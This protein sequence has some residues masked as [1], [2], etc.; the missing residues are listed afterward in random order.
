MTVKQNVSIKKNKFIHG[1]IA[2]LAIIA[3]GLA[4]LYFYLNSENFRIN[5]KHILTSQ[6]EN[7]LDKKIEIGSVD[8]ISLHSI[9]LSNL[10]ILENNKD[11][12]EI[13]FQSKEAEIR[14]FIFLPLLQGGKKW[15]LD[16]KEITFIEAN[17]A[18]TRDFNGDFDL[19]KKFQLDLEFLNENIA[20][21]QINFKNSLLIYND[22]SVYHKDYITVE[23]RDLNGSFDL[24]HL[25]EIKFEMRAIQAPDEA[26]LALS[27]FFFVGKIEYSLDFNLQNA[28]LT[29]FQ[30]Y[31]E[32][33]E[34]F[35]ISQGKFNLD[36][37]LSHSS[38]W[39]S[40]DILW[41]GEATFY[42][43]NAQPY[44]L[45]EMSFQQI[46]GSVN[47]SKPEIIISNL[48]GLHY[49]HTI[50]LEGLIQTA[51]ETSYNLK[52]EGK[53][54]EAPL[55]KDDISLFTGKNYDFTLEGEVDL[56]GN[57]NGLA[58]TF[59]FQGKINSSEI[60]IEETSFSTISGNFTL[61]NKWLI[62][63][64][65]KS[66]DSNGSILIDGNI[67]W[68]QD[69]SSY[70]FIVK[71]FDLS[72][73]HS[74]FKHFLA[75][76]DFS[77]NM[78]SQFQIESQI[79][80]S[81]KSNLSGIFSI[82]KIKKGDFALPDPLKGSIEAIIDLSDNMFSIE[83]CE[84]Q[85]SGSS[86]SVKGDIRFEEM[87][88]FTFDFNYQIPNLTA[89]SP[90]FQKDPKIAGYLALQG[91]AKGNI[92][93]PE[94]V[95]VLELSKFSIQDHP[96]EELRGRL[97]Y[98]KD[99]LSIESFN[100]TNQDLKMAAE[101]KI[102]L[103]QPDKP[104]INLSY[105]MAPLSLDPLLKAIGYS[106]PLSGQV[107][108]NGYIQ[109]IWPLLEVDG[110]F[111]L[112]EI[113]YENY[114]LGQGEANFHLQ[115]EQGQKTAYKNQEINFDNFF[116]EIGHYYSLDLEHLKLQNETIEIN[117]KG[118]A[119]MNE[120]NPFSLEIEFSHQRFEEMI[121]HFYPTQENIKKFLPSRITGKIS[122]T[123][124]NDK[125]NFLLSTLLI[126]QEEENNPPSRLEAVFTVN[127]GAL[128]I[129]DF[130]LIQSE[131]LLKAEGV[132]SSDRS[133]DINFQAS[134]LDLAN[135]IASL[136]IDEEIKGIMDIKGFCIGT[137]EQ[138]I[139]SI[140]AK[141]KEGYF[142]EF[143]YENLHSELIWSSLTN[144]IEI[145]ELTID[146]EEK[147]QITARGNIPAESFIF[148]KKEELELAPTYSGIPLDF[149][150][151]ME[152]ADL[153][154]LKVF[155][156]DTF[157]EITG[158]LG[159]KLSF[160]GTADHPVVNG[161]IDIYQGQVQ[162]NELPVQIEE[163]NDSIRIINNRVTMPSISFRAYQNRFI[164]SGEFEL[165]HFLPN[166]MS[167]IIKNEDKRIIYQ[168]ILDSEVDLELVIKNSILSPKISGQVL[169]SNGILNVNNLLK[170]R[171]DMYLS[172]SPSLPNSNSLEQ[173]EVN[174]EL[175]EPFKLKMSNAEIEIGGKIILNGSLVA[176]TPKGTLSLKKGYFIY[177][178]KRFSVLDGLVTING[179]NPEDIELNAGAN[180]HV[181]GVQININVLGNL[182]HPQILLSS[183]PSLKETEILSLLAFDRNIQ[184]LSE[185]EI[186]Q[187]LSQEMV[188]IIFQ[189]L[190]MNLF[191]RIER[192]IAEGLGLE[193]LRISLN[194]QENGG[195]PFFLEDLHLSDLTLEVGKNIGDNLL[196]TYSTPL[197]FHGESSL[198]LDVKLAPDFTFST[199]LETYSLKK[200]D[201]KIRFGLEIRF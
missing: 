81:A 31:L 114:P 46:S 185:G 44:F 73:R 99:I 119:K 13:L 172:F 76:Q 69:L 147:Y 166:N 173:L 7:I 182:L 158:T 168:D 15:K 151:N 22:E 70:Q 58:D 36:L 96:F 52:I 137:L 97:T 121:E 109:G 107:E 176:P 138:P 48:T 33:A 180:T 143:H 123:G 16:I 113:I 179:I 6:M 189:S 148:P 198:G 2:L 112:E 57:I 139:I 193:F 21:E 90:A 145:K 9:H 195:T 3:L 156:K 104:E 126:P 160:S 11:E 152:K 171:E 110:V 184:G 35:N 18:L 101:G 102:I 25:P 67:N 115:P 71:T 83:K 55:L 86:G 170:M 59:S 72:L 89:Y 27:G 39:D 5:L 32:A 188:N 56:W 177:F 65:L 155:W 43:A 41:Q 54:L 77:G 127:K 187:L 128:N 192:E 68:D 167:F 140:I 66:Q 200:E 98:G 181:Q 153:N 94:I 124:N 62:I 87:V 30:Y 120:G 92:L 164:L 95:I 116:T 190:Q 100:L 20:I 19:V 61:N 162:F 34:Q 130:K 131:G 23:A 196:I 141:I 79:P 175:L 49:D 74:L 29:H 150:I 135:L 146:L 111:Q 64:D 169:L 136:A 186:S 26:I 12:A 178:D 122:C 183:Q 165:I 191:R 144:Q 134:Q 199:Q 78:E 8:T 159:L 106:A 157:S 17:T 1:F 38:E 51:P 45:K 50:Q 105:Q 88:N 132:I 53:H 40:D 80:D 24:T 14:F 85:S 197:D 4:L 103:S 28:D 10:K 194:N 142:R 118:Q 163:I 154:L 60:I 75:L 117:A 201:Y 47:F 108:G 161:K 149:Q 91:K 93:Q 174:I 82:N 129:S 133:L 37:N 125:Q 84:L 63:N 42:E